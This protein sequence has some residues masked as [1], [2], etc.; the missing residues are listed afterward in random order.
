[1]YDRVRRA[2]YGYGIALVLFRGLRWLS[3]MGREEHQ[4]ELAAFLTFDIEA[5]SQVAYLLVL[6]PHTEGGGFHL[7]TEGLVF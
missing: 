7:H 3:L 2:L 6:I 1:L 5:V 4:R